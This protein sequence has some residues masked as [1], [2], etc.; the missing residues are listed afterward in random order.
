MENDEVNRAVDLFYDDIKRFA[1]VACKNI[2]DAEDITQNVFLKLSNYTGIFE[3]DEHLKN[4]LVRVTKNE[5]SSFLRSPWKKRVDLYIP[6][7]IKG[8]LNNYIEHPY[9]YDAL[10]N[11][12]KKYREVIIL[13]YYEEYSVKETA[14][15]LKITQST[16]LKRL[17]RARGM[18]KKYIFEKEHIT[19]ELTDE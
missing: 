14:E 10:L 3:N 19:G 9:V 5:Y 2:H 17:E 6:E 7:Q 1:Y 13:F 15:I 8:S 16:V 12:K 18:M 11:L 4:W